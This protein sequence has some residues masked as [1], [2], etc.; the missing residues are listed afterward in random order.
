MLSESILQIAARN[1]P[2][3]R[4]VLLHISNKNWCSSKEIALCTHDDIILNILHKKADYQIITFGCY[5]SNF[6]TDVAHQKPSSAV[7][8]LP[9]V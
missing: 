1:F 7:F 4:P 5:P 9:N 8:I 3:D 2:R 6:S